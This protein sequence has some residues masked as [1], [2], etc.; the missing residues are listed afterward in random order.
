VQRPSP[1][2]MIQGQSSSGR[3]T[4]SSLPRGPYKSVEAVLQCGD[5]DKVA[6]LKVFGHAAVP[7]ASSCAYSFLR[8]MRWASCLSG[9]MKQSIL[10]PI[11]FFAPSP[12]VKLR[13][14]LICS[15]V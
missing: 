4:T 14:F 1:L 6:E 9:F 13:M 2:R 11:A 3:R 8:P 7:G 5:R 12:N 15:T 10:L